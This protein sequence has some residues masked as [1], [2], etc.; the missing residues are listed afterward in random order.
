MLTIIF[1]VALIYVT[2]KLFVLDVG[3]LGAM[4]NLKASTMIDGNK[5]FVTPKKAIELKAFELKENDII[6]SRSGTV[7]KICVVPKRMDGALLSTN[8]IRISLNRNMINENF[9]VYLFHFVAL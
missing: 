5:I 9:F 8:L 3:L 2:F 4:T 7:G 6:I 1:F